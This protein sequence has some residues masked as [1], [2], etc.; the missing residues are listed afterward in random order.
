MALEL[1]RLIRNLANLKHKQ[2]MKNKFLKTKPKIQ[3]MKQ[4]VEKANE[5]AFQNLLRNTHAISGLDLGQ[6]EG[7]LFNF[8]TIIEFFKQKQSSVRM[9]RG[10]YLAEGITVSSF[11]PMRP[12]PFKAVFLLGLGEGLFPSALRKD[13]LDLRHI[14]E[15][16]DPP[17]EGKNFRERRIGDV[18]ETERDRYMFLE[19]LISTRKNLVLSYVSHSD[20]TDDELSPSS[21]IQTLLDELDR[22]YLKNKFNE[23]IHPLKSYSLSY[24]PEL[25]NNDKKNSLTSNMKKVESTENQTDVNFL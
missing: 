17:I 3:E 5:E 13:T 23:T 8:K 12:I 7:H 16:L 18:S 10:H 15:R 1:K 21:I 25:G 4:N 22:G 6:E 20:K 19:T 9:H 11:K 14:P 24:F 2:T